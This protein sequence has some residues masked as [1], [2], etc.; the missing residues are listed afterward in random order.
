MHKERANKKGRARMIVPAGQM[1]CH[2]SWDSSTYI[3]SL[4]MFRASRP[5]FAE[6]NVTH[7]QGNIQDVSS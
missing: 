7:G 2:G 4:Y 1:A 3:T 6:A 5:S